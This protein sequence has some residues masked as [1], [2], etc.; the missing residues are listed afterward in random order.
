M[1]ILVDKVC[2]FD[3][4]YTNILFSPII[5][6]KQKMQYGKDDPLLSSSMQARKF[7]ITEAMSLLVLHVTQM[8]GTTC[9]KALPSRQILLPCPYVHY[10]LETTTLSHHHLR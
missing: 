4:R 6:S 2:L 5:T 10:H 1:K 8:L 9:E 3:F 7:L